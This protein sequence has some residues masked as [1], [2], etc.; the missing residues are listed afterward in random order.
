MII[1]QIF[2]LL[3]A[4]NLAVAEHLYQYIDKSGNL[5]VTNKKTPGSTPFYLGTNEDARHKILQEELEHEKTAIKQI[6]AMPGDKIA[7][8]N[9]DKA[10][11]QR[12]INILTKQLNQD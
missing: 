8:Y 10:L 11:H 3:F 5:V 1:F 7:S 12:N 2:L 4:C 6:N 9:N